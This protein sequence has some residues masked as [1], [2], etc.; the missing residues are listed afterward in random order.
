MKYFT[1]PQ[2]IFEIKIPL[3]W[4]Y[5]NEVAG[6]K[7]RPPFSFEQFENTMG[8]F[9]ISCYHV[10]EWKAN[11]LLPLQGYN[12]TNL[13]FHKAEFTNDEFKFFIGET[14]SGD[15]YFLAKYFYEANNVNL[16]GINSEIAKAENCLS[17]LVCLSSDQREYAVGFDRYEKF[18][19]S[20][21][22]S[23]DLKQKAM[24]NSS[25]IELIIINA[26]HIDAYL[27]LC[28]VFLYQI[29]E[30]T[31]LFKMEYLFQGEKDKHLVE[32]RIYDKAK[33]LEIITDEQYQKLNTLYD[34]RNKV[35]HRYIITDIKTFELVE[36]SYEY[37]ILCEEIRI[38]LRN[39][40]AEQFQKKV[41]YHGQKDP[42][43]ERDKSH[44]DLISSMVNDK[45][46]LR[47][48]IEI[49]NYTMLINYPICRIPSSNKLP[50]FD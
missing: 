29:S 22:A 34:R 21:A 39:L 4:L 7:N 44:F 16:I 12:T 8:C 46:F 24:K 3:D 42:Y 41:G 50:R 15:Y 31:S 26:N 25:F 37:E 43:R 18:C 48:T 27:R 35:V 6:L 2:G 14:I 23:F 30:S 13:K 49:C 20:L 40:E 1:H 38:V 9:Q 28:I 45:H 32:K 19:A 11:P 47:N 10:S 17:T 33:E 36:I 5:K